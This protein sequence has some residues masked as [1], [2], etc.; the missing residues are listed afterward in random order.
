MEYISIF[1]RW[2]E[3]CFSQQQC[4]VTQSSRFHDGT[5]EMKPQALKTLDTE[6]DIIQIHTLYELFPK[7]GDALVKFHIKT[8]AIQ[9][10][11][12]IYV[13]V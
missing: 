1:F 5:S 13:N 11:H 4:N 9:V 10:N 7:E 8:M 3:I 12:F 2:E 6:M